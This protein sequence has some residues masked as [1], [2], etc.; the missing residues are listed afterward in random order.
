MYVCIY[1]ARDKSFLPALLFMNINIIKW[2]KCIKNNL[3]FA[4]KSL[5]SI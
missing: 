4:I 1:T 2:F 3:P 5:N